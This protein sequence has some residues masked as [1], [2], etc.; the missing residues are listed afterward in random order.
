MFSER[1]PSN[2]KSDNYLKCL[3]QKVPGEGEDKCGSQP[4]ESLKLE[5]P[6]SGEVGE[7]DVLTKTCGWNLRA[8][9]G[10]LFPPGGQQLIPTGV[11]SWLVQI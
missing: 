11:Y 9:T 5:L 2:K 10:M 6:V 1:D 8:T 3:H 4:S 7:G